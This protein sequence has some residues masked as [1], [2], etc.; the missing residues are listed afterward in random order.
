MEEMK[1]D[2]NTNLE[3]FV[4]QIERELPTGTVIHKKIGVSWEVIA[5]KVYYC[6]R[7]D[8]K[9]YADFLPRVFYTASQEEAAKAVLDIWDGAI[10]AYQKTLSHQEQ[11]RAEVEKKWKS[12]R[13]KYERA[14]NL[15]ARFCRISTD[16]LAYIR[17]ETGNESYIPVYDVEYDPLDIDYDK[18][19]RENKQKLIER[20]KPVLEKIPIKQSQRLAAFYNGYAALADTPLVACVSIMTED[21]RQ[22]LKKEIDG[23]TGTAKE[24]LP[25]AVNHANVLPDWYGIRQGEKAQLGGGWKTVWRDFETKAKNAWYPYALRVAALVLVFPAWE[26]TELE[27]ELFMEYALVLDDT[28]RHMIL[29]KAKEL[30]SPGNIQPHHTLEEIKPFISKITGEQET[31]EH[32][33]EL[34]IASEVYDM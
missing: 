29:G 9:N 6:S 18:I 19:T 21:A 28:Q 20:M 22:I 13:P 16:E 17:A 23:M 5:N 10:S 7:N 8:V 15:A 24:Q 12:E 30:L 26:M 11:H 4:F 2:P 33:F 31:L 3:E 25:R 1:I 34:E 32:Y 27:L 14:L